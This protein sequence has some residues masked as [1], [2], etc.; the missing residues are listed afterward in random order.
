MELMD[1]NTEAERWNSYFYPGTQVL[2]NKLNI[3]NGDELKEKEAQI[4]FEKLVELYENPIIGKFDSN[5]L[6]DIHRFIFEDLYD[7]AGELVNIG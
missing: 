5:H 7:W 3:T 4:S 2:K 6:R 1:K